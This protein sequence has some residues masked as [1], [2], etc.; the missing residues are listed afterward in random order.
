MGRLC[1]QKPYANRTRSRSGECA[2]LGDEV[3]YALRGVESHAG[4]GAAYQGHLG[5]RAEPLALVSLELGLGS[6][7]SASAS[8]SASA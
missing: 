1:V 5:A 4:G 6:K 3:V 2:A 8:A 7:A